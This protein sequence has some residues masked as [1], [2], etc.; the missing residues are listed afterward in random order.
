MKKITLLFALLLSL[1]GVTQ[2]AADELT[3]Y[4]G[5]N[6]NDY[7]PV[8]GYYADAY[9]KCEFIIPAADLADMNGSQVSE[10]KFYSSSSSVSWGDAVFKV[11]LKE[12]ENTVISAFSGDADATTVYEGSLSIS[13]GQMVVSFSEDYTYN[14]GNLLVGVYETTIGS[15]NKA[16]FYGVSQDVQTAFR[17]Y[18]SSS[19]NSVS[20]SAQYFLPKTTFT[21][22]QTVEG[23]GLVVKDG[24]TKISEGYTYNFGLTAPTTTHVFTLSNPGTVDLELSVSGDC[25]PTLSANTIPAGDDITLTITMPEQSV[26]GIVIISPNTQLINAFPIYV[27]G[28]A[29]DPN[30]LFVDFADGSMPEGWSNVMIGQYGSGWVINTGYASHS[31]SAS[32]YYLAALTSPLL[33]FTEGESFFFDVSKYGSASYNTA[34]IKLQMS[35]DGNNWSDV[36][37]VPESDL[38]YGEWKTQIVSMPAG[39]Y[40]IR[41]YGGYANITNIYGGELPMIANMKVTAEDHNFG[42]I[43]EESTTTFTI[44]NTG[45]TELTDIEVSSDNF[46]FT[47]EDAPTSLGAG[48]EATVTVKMGIAAMGVQS[49]VITVSAPDQTSVTFNVSG[50]VAD[51]DKLMITFGDN[52]VPENWENTGWTFSAGVATGTYSSSTSSRNSEMVTP[53]IQVGEGETMAIEAMGTSS[54]YA[55]LYVY[56]STDGGTTWTKVGDFNTQMR[57]N[58]SDY[59]V[60]V[61][62]GLEAGTYLFKFEGYSV[63]VNTI[64]GF[65]YDQNAPVMTVTP[66]EDATFG[67]VTDIAT[68]TYTISNTG[69]GVLT[70]NLASDSEDF[71]VEPELIIVGAEDEPVSFTVTFNYDGENLGEKSGNITLTPFH[72]ETAVVTIAASAIAKDPNVWDE[73]FE[74]GTLP[75][76]WLSEGK[77][78]V[79]Q[80]TASGSNGTYMAYISSY[81]APKALTTPCLEAKA[82]DQLTFYIG[83]Q[84]DDE[85]LTIEYSA[86]DRATW[87]VIEEGVESYT[88]SGTIT[89][90]APADGTYYLRFTGTYAMLDDFNGFKLFQKAHDALITSQNI[91]ATGNQYVEYTATVTVKEMADKDENVKVEFYFGETKMGE[92]EG[93]LDPKSEETFEVKFIPEEAFEGEAY[94]KVTFVSDDDEVFA[95][96]N[97]DPVAVTIAAAPVLDEATGSLEGFENWGNYPVVSMKYSLKAGWNTIILPFAWSD[98]SVFG[99]GA[100]VYEFTG[101]TA[102]DGISFN[103]K[104]SM[105]AQKPYVLYAPEA[106]TDIVFTD[107][108]MFRS[109]TEAADLQTTKDEAVFQGSY[110]PVEAP[111]M[112]GK[113]GVVPS[114]G[115]IAKGGANAYIKGFRAYFELPTSVGEVKANFF[116]AD[117]TVTSIEAV[118]VLNA[119]EGAIFDLSGRKVEGKAKAGIYIQNGKKIVVK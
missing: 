49:G 8:Y 23:P 88:E 18:N 84:Y 77:W 87:S 16:S 72:D 95:T 22:E 75:E 85:P 36:Y 53:A 108:K 63:K 52:K 2:V 33:S 101:Y 5:T 45:R 74:E 12:V 4:D 19:L 109:S 111:N 66:L 40:Y 110:A 92:V 15:Y 106:K 119:N 21:Y 82:G 78:T 99:E 94:F 58:T 68:K 39:N 26:D 43:I 62:S 59:T 25:D 117:G 64:N 31:N 91:P 60:A 107:V 37:T 118:K 27:K 90:T 103:A 115:K 50:Y 104:T 70:V 67:K 3:V 10:M 56:T 71:T 100:K 83:M 1:L 54:S 29:K 73:D 7:V 76:S 57:D 44:K 86:D 11:F 96:F 98:L 20:G 30:K 13:G 17:G 89:F 80:P 6:T 35:T 79:S 9:Q 14:G 46:T 112:Q 81:N 61:L 114:T 24:S 93:T 105:D 69:T 41:F 116:E 42:L 55:E 48:E 32:S 113:Y 34:Q 47:I 28:T 51:P 97:S 38:V 65:Q 102:A